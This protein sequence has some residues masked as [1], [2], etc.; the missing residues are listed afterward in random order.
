MENMLYH[1]AVPEA[2]QD[3]YVQFNNV[4]FVLN[5]GE[6]RSL[7]RNSVRLCGEVEITSDGTTTSDSRV[8]MDHA[9]G[10]HSTVSSVQT[11][12]GT[13]GTKENIQN[14][15]RWVKMLAIGTIY[16]DDYNN[17]SNQVELRAVNGI[18]AGKLAK[19]E[20]TVN[21]GTKLSTDCDFAMKPVCILNR[22][23]GDHL[24]FEKSGEVR[25]TFNLARNAS[26]LMG[27]NQGSGATYALKNLHVSYQSVP[28][29]GDPMSKQV[30]MRS[31][32]NIK[33][34]IQSGSA[35]ISA[36]VP[37]T[38]SGVSCSFQRQQDEN[39]N[40]FINYECN[41]V[42]GI[43][44]VQFEF[45]DS[46]NKY[47]SY[48]ENDLGSMVERYID[49]FDNTGHQQMKLDCFRT[50]NGFGI[51]QKFSSFVDLSSQRFG[52]QLTSDITN[53]KPLNMYSYFHSVVVA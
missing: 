24:P 48:N 38:V 46:T 52:I 20:V 43:R 44:R 7:L 39:V 45:K 12:F 5:V 2:T 33:S 4:D 50:N 3:T 37:A 34:T 14:Y 47:V 30:S 13:S 17:A 8:Y 18:S 22:M 11:S 53:Q 51:G 23:S 27:P 15:A 9:I 31:V 16:E 1:S 35:N 36:Q 40:V 49:S 19:G 42:E 21:S 26:A 32:Y 6:G 41:M 10:I 28:T 29:L 25:L